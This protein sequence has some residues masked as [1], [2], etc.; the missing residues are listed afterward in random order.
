MTAFLLLT[1]LA[2]GDDT[3]DTATVPLLGP[4]LSHAPPEGPFVAGD[5]ISLEVEASDDDGVDVVDLVYRASEGDYWETVEMAP[6]SGEIWTMDVPSGDVAAPGVEY[7]FRATDAVGIT[8]FL[9]LGNASDP[10]ELTVADKGLLLPFAEDFEDY[11]PGY[12]PLYSI[13]WASVGS[14]F[15]GYPFEI[16]EAQAQDGVASVFHPRGYEGMS[17]L[18][19]W[20]LAPALDFT[21]VDRIQLTWWEQGR[22]VE[23][24]DHSLW[25]STSDRDPRNGT[26]VEVATLSAPTEDWTRSEVI[27]LTAWADEPVVHLAWHYV[28]TYADDWYLDAVSVKEMTCDPELTVSWDRE[29]VSPGEQVGIAVE[30][31]N[32]ID[33]AC[34]DLTATLTFP[35]GGATTDDATLSLGDLESEG[36]LSGLYGVSIDVDWPDNSYLP[37]ELDLTDGTDT[38]LLREKL[39]V[40]QTSEV[41]LDFEMTSEGLVQ[42]VFG[43]GD[44]DSPTWESDPVA[45]TVS[46]GTTAWSLDVTD[47][48]ALLPPG[49]GTERWFARLDTGGTGAVTAFE[50]DYGGETSAASVLP[51]W[52]GTEDHVVYVPE[53]PDPEILSLTTSPS[54][55]EPGDLVVIDL[56]L[57]NQG[58]HTVG[59][60]Q[61]TLSSTDDAVTIHTVDPVQVTAGVWGEGVTKDL[62]DAFSFTVSEGHVDSSD[63]P[64]ELT[65]TDGVESWVLPFE[66]SVPWPVIKVTSVEIDDE[67]GGNG[68]GLLDPG[69][70]ATL[71]VE[72]TN[73]GDVSADGFVTAVLVD[74]V[75]STATFTLD[76]DT[77]E[78]STLTVGSSREAKFEVTVSA[79]ATPGQTLVLRVD[80]TDDHETYQAPFSITLGEPP[81]LSISSTDDDIGDANGYTLDLVNVQYRSDGET[82]ELLFQAAEPFDTSTAFV[83]M[84]A[85]STGLSYRYY[86]LVLQSGAATLQGY[87]SGFVELG[88]PSVDYPSSTEVKLSWPVSEMEDDSISSLRVGFGAGWCAAE[89]SNYCDHFP[90]GWGYYYTSY[91]DARFFTLEW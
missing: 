68:D 27:D 29:E 81:W 41:R 4:V 91:T 40:G 34:A 36:E 77:D 42:V 12:G 63:L 21:G 61:A 11:T 87:D 62:D 22:S 16:T 65:L 49:P 67:D 14:G 3:D 8:S 44:P 89:T 5:T 32:R 79:G 56:G 23:L 19:D 72:L 55:L 18:D 17:S 48:H 9:P 64:F 45:E 84:W 83:E 51:S 2:C 6:G 28:G 76:V 1:V 90:D 69:E 35:D 59:G 15:G 80:A 30:V 50:V 26:H 47:Q 75:A 88:E 37:V 10:Y 52:W 86:R 71:E 66:L 31:A 33:V 46:A 82:L 74:E 54:T 25:L 7:Y 70:S 53:P 24:S 85:I 39:V 73:V 60:V 20:L 78:L 58:S 57:R 38:W 43:A 13:G